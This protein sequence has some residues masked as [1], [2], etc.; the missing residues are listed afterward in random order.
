MPVGGMRHIDEPI[1][2]K[3]CKHIKKH[4]LKIV[5]KINRFEGL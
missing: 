3:A 1:F 2:I 5:F 4:K